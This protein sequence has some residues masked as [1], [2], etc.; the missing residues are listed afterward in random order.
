MSQLS[1]KW[2][3]RLMGAG[4]VLSI[5]ATPSLA[6]DSGRANT[7]EDFKSAES[8]DGIFGSDRSIFDLFHQSGALSGAGVIDDG[9]FRGQSRQISREAESLRERQR[10]ILEAQSLEAAPT[11]DAETAE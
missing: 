5:A 3:I 1:M 8:S 4:F 6:Q 10:A 11:T 9:F 2:A 7:A